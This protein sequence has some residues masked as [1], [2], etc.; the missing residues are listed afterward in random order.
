MSC[1]SG[2]D[3][4]HQWTATMCGDVPGCFG[5]GC[6][7]LP[8]QPVDGAPTAAGQI[9]FNGYTPI[10]CDLL[11]QCGD[12]TT[13]TVTADFDGCNTVTPFS[14][15]VCDGPVDA[16]WD[17]AADGSTDATAD[18]GE[19]DATDDAAFDGSDASD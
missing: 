14:A 3:Y 10:S 9:V 18:G 4:N 6:G 5:I 12:G 8:P 2:D 17:S 11:I 7:G 19:V 15:T 13:T 16:G 1:T